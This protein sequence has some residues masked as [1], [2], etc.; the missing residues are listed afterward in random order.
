MSE[1]YICN[2]P[3]LFCSTTLAQIHKASN[4]SFLKPSVGSYLPRKPRKPRKPN[5]DQTAIYFETLK[6]A[7]HG[8][9]PSSTRKRHSPEAWRSDRDLLFFSHAPNSLNRV[10]V[11]HGLSHFGGSVVPHPSPTCPSNSEHVSP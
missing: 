11:W 10:A 7:G 2:R 6:L 3:H 4:S 8:S 1:R 9:I 5:T